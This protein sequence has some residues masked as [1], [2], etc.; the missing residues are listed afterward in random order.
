MDVSTDGSGDDSNKKGLLLEDCPGDN[1]DDG[2]M[3]G[4]R[5]KVGVV[6]IPVVV[7]VVEGDL[8]GTLCSPIVI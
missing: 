2:T 8:V 1:D 6:G 4:G 5:L 3:D 7:V